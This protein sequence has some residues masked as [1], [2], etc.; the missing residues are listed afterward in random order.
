[1]KLK[2]RANAAK[3]LVEPLIWGIAAL[4]AL[5]WVARPAWNLEP[6]VVFFTISA[7]SFPIY[8]YR[9][10]P[11]L[12][13]WRVSKQ[14]FRSLVVS[15]P[16]HALEGNAESFLDGV[17]FKLNRQPVPNYPEKISVFFRQT[18]LCAM[19]LFGDGS[20]A[21]IDLNFIVGSIDDECHMPKDTNNYFIAQFDI[22]ADGLDEI[23][24]GVIDEEGPQSSC[25]LRVCKYYPPFDS[26]DV[27]RLENWKYFDCQA[28]GIIGNVSI[29][30]TSRSV[31]I[32]RN[33]RDLYFKWLF[34][35][36][37]QIDRHTA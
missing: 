1:M 29:R 2:E 3:A 9:I 8:H 7:S 36:G 22:D 5:V 4:L 20:Q 37:E 31:K 32:P 30:I 13:E 18:R 10:R 26:N 28:F 34:V 27:Q 33:H 11:K 25:Q 12:D 35:D 14:S 6:W 21:D 16:I 19:V 17:E 15:K 23:I 24:I